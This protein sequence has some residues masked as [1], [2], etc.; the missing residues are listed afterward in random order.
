MD[1]ADVSQQAMI[2][3]RFCGGRCKAPAIIIAVMLAAAAVGLTCLYWPTSISTLPKF[4]DVVSIHALFGDLN[5]N[6][7]VSEFELPE[8]FWRP[9]FNCLSPAVYDPA[10]AKWQTLGTFVAHMIDGQTV[11]I[12]LYRVTEN[13][14]AFSVEPDGERK[15][16]YRGGSLS[17]LLDAL[18]KARASAG[19][20]DDGAAAWPAR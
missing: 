18:S 10:P 14:I 7:D 13:E 1:E 6:R 16:Y 15:T 5:A 9:I 11:Q 8:K 20:P 19:M 3:R 4:E 2:Y 17:S 12:W